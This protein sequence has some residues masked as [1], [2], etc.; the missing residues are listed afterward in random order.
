ME[1]IWCGL[2]VKTVCDHL[3][4]GVKSGI[5]YVWRN[6][7]GSAIDSLKKEWEGVKLMEDVIPF[8][9]TL[10]LSPSAV[11]AEDCVL[12]IAAAVKERLG[13]SH[14]VFV[15]AAESMVNWVKLW[16]VVRSQVSS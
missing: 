5:P 11:T 14:S 15:S 2:V 8:F 4:L 6:E 3:Q 10:R 12:E 7:K 9:E 16:K 1:D 13:S